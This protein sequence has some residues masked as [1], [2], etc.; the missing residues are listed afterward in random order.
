MEAGDFCALEALSAA[1]ASGGLSFDPPF[2][3]S[4]FEYYLLLSADAVPDMTL[5]LS[6]VAAHAQSVVRVG[7]LYGAVVPA[8]AAVAVG[9]QLGDNK[10]SGAPRRAAA[11]LAAGKADEP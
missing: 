9:L 1:S 4:V 8:G 5:H 2:S 3:A 11:Q 7:G 6:A 10:A